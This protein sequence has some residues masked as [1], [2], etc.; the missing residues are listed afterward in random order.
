MQ[1]QLIHFIWYRKLFNQE[2]LTT[3]EGHSVQILHTG[4]PNKDQGPDFL[5]ARIRVDDQLWA[6][7]VEIHILSSSWYLHMH[8]Q[9]THYNNVILHVVWTEDQPVFT[10]AGSRI[11]CIE[12]K[13][14]IDQLLLERYNH[15]MNNEE[16]IPCASSLQMIPEIT[17]TSWLERLMSERLESKTD[18]IC[19]ILKQ[20][21][22]DWEQTFFV[23]LA[24]QLGAPAN[25]DAMESL[26]LKIPLNLLRKHG[27]RTDQIEAILFGVAGMLTSEIGTGYPVLLK[28]EFDFLKDK[29]SLQPMP[30]L[31][32]KF[33]RMRP[34]HFPTIRIAQ[35]AKIIAGTTQF[36]SLLAEIES[37]DDWI[38]I[39][40]ITPDNSYWQ[41]HFHFKS[42][43]SISDK[44]LGR[45]TAV[46]LVINVIAP[47][48]F[49]YGKMQGLE[50]I[51]ECSIKFLSQMPSEKNAVIKGWNKCGWSAQDAGQTQAMLHLKKY[52]CDSRRCLHC[53]IGL[54]VMKE[55]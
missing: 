31:R 12:L 55:G 3:T 11:P 39:F 8:D 13:G 22:N 28:K 20:C 18:F 48:M 25:S 51:K 45:E 4:I 6:G 53:A 14:R 15:L 46:S 24:R 38:K 29:Y 35:L 26:A 27:D 40:M 5:Q 32:W 21:G 52:Y 36:V 43:S 1:E 50:K 44:R 7:H 41:N 2:G 47:Y 17:K 23:V 54:K 37:P 19:R 42:T 10:Q 34:V 9:D 49:V 33:M 16:W 30:S